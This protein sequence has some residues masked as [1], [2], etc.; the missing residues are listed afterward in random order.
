MFRSTEISSS[1]STASSWLTSMHDPT[2]K[3]CVQRILCP[4]KLTSFNLLNQLGSPSE[5]WSEHVVQFLFH[6]FPREIVYKEMK[7]SSDGFSRCCTAF[8]RIQR[9]FQMLYPFLIAHAFLYGHLL[10]G[11]VVLWCFV[12]SFPGS[13]SRLY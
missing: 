9:L 13:L 5:V 7:D 4:V 11:G 2:L 1:S 3:S 6:L 10:D 8:C 12:P